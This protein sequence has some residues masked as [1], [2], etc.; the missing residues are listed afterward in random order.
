MKGAQEA[1]RAMEMGYLLSSFVY[2]LSYCGSFNLVYRSFYPQNEPGN[3]PF[4]FS[5]P[6]CLTVSLFRVHPDHFL[7]PISHTLPIYPDFSVYHQNV[8]FVT[9]HPSPRRAPEGRPP[10]ILSSLLRQAHKFVVFPPENANDRGRLPSFILLQNTR[11][12]TP[13]GCLPWG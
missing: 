6:N 2:L 11:K 1:A 4:C 5:W 12:M 9:G 8:T 7:D 3:E 10:I 13:A